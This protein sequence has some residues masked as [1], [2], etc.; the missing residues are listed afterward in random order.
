MLGMLGFLHGS[1][2]ALR[3]RL[4]GLLGSLLILNENTFCFAFARKSR[5]TPKT[6]TGNAGAMNFQ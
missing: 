6:S 5:L 2:T 1:L 3:N 4:S